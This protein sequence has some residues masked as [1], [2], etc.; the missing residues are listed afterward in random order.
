ML[1]RFTQTRHLFVYTPVV[2]VVP[3]HWLQIQSEFNINS[4]ILYIVR[5]NE[6]FGD[7]HILTAY[8]SYFV[9]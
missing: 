6:E 2:S 8:F 5:H 1:F 9:V 7:T 4:K 3:Q